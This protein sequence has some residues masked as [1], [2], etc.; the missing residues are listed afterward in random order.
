MTPDHIA[1]TYLDRIS[2]AVM[3]NDYADYRQGMTLP[4]HMITYASNITIT[5]EDDLRDGFDAFR[6]LLQSQHVTDYIRLVSSAEQMDAD[7]ITARYVTHL[8][9]G[10]QRIIDP[11]H[12]QIS[13][14]LV[15]GRWVAASITN[16]LS[17]SRWPLDVLRG[18]ASD[19]SKGS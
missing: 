19:P 3:A 4:F 7:L 14:R 1:Q 8:I 16:A 15:E 13:L 10:A 17:T 2:A 6:Q 5:T 18:T 12:S 11:F 9:A